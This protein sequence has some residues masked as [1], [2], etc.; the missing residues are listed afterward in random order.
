M[1][2][3]QARDEPTPVVQG[4]SHHIQ[5]DAV[6]RSGA[7]GVGLRM[8]G[9]VVWLSV[10][11]SSCAAAGPVFSAASAAVGLAQLHQGSETTE[12]QH[13]QTPS[14]PDTSVRLNEAMMM[15]S[16]FRLLEPADMSD[17]PPGMTHFVVTDAQLVRVRHY[18]RPLS[19]ESRFTSGQIA[20]PAIAAASSSATMRSS[21]PPRRR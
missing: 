7:S 5:V 20:S 14:R 13:P 3:E 21:R 4:G 12:Q 11:A 10:F 19:P 17:L 2:E 9:W 18:S 6:M 1:V 16:G 15:K 8:S